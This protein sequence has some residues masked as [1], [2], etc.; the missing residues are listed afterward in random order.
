MA[1]SLGV[2][3]EQ[4]YLAG[5]AAEV[6]TFVIATDG[7]SIYCKKCKRRSFSSGDVANRYCGFCHHFHDFL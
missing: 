6:E 5:L 7:K 4:T 2:M 3:P 1:R